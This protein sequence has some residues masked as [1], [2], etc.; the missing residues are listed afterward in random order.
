MT[1]DLGQPK[2]ENIPIPSK[3]QTFQNQ[4]KNKGFS[5][6]GS[7]VFTIAFRGIKRSLA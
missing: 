7:G 1:L 4:R 5:H 2:R 3:P 6:C